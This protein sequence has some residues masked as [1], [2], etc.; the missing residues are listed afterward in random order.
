MEIN[1]ALVQSSLVEK[2]LL[3][4]EH[5]VMLLNVRQYK[6]K[7]PRRLCLNYEDIGQNLLLN[8]LDFIFYHLTHLSS[9]ND[10]TSRK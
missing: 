5:Q 6:L 2:A 7:P 4:L 3:V 10:F 8:Y 9:N 1:P